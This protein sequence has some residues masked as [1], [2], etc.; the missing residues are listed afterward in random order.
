M[1]ARA[2]GWA[3]ASDCDECT[4]KLFFTADG[5]ASWA[6]YR[7][8]GVHIAR[9]A[10]SVQF[11][12]RPHGWLSADDGALYATSDGGRSWQLVSR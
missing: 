12:D 9:R 3:L 6:E 11:V 8:R 4:L 1:S 7:P 5:G 10:P 2:W